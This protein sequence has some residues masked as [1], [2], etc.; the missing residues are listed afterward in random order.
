MNNNM[1]VTDLN[2]CFIKEMQTLYFSL[3]YFWIRQT[4]QNYYKSQLV[5]KNL[6]NSLTV[7]KNL[8]LN[9]IQTV[10]VTSKY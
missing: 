6:P 2:V 10:Y 9:N 7:F 5:K 3:S 8:N 4:V 1:N